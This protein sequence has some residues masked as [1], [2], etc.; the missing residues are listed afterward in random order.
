MPMLQ[1]EHLELREILKYP[2]LIVH[3]WQ[4]PGFNSNFKRRIFPCSTWTHVLG[5]AGAAIIIQDND[6]F[7]NIKKTVLSSKE[8]II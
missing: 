6:F 8:F 5:V 7:F 1:M 2:N 3:R 4:E